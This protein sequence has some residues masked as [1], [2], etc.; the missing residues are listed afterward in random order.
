MLA[1]VLA[2]AAAAR[3]HWRRRGLRGTGSAAAPPESTASLP[4][5]TP[6]P[7]V[8]ERTG[9]LVAN[10]E[11]VLVSLL[12]VV[13]ARIRLVVALGAILVVLAIVPAEWSLSTRALLAWDCGAVL[14]LALAWSLMLPASAARTRRGAQI[15]RDGAPMVL[16]LTVAAAMTSLAAI[17]LELS[18]LQVLTPAEQH[19]HIGLVVATLIVS[20]LLVHTAFA[21]HYASVVYETDRPEGTQALEFPRGLPPVYV[22]FLYFAFVVGMTAQTSD[23]AVTTTAMRRLV[24]IH[25]MIGFF[26][27]TALLALTI[28][29]AGSILD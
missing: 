14:Y 25:A 23:V 1:L 11:S 15:Q 21:L 18:G 26:F 20:W 22:D 7:T 28:N 19:L 12:R 8:P 9:S 13:H 24:T 5:G 16:F 3:W 17:L 10:R 27:N 2:A 6:P 29:I 4:A